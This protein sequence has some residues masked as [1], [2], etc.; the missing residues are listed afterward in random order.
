MTEEEKQAGRARFLRAVENAK[1]VLKPGDR[2]RVTKC[3]GRKRTITFAGWDGCWMVSKSGV[4]DYS[5]GCVDR[6]NGEEVDFGVV[7]EDRAD[8][9][10]RAN[11]AE[12]PKKVLKP[13]VLRAHDL[14]QQYRERCPRC[15]GE[16][17]PWAADGVR[18][19][20]CEN[21][22]VSEYLPPPSSEG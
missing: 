19:R 22:C 6:V 21:G 17:M 2:V 16:W 7:G 5:A 1:K 20:A 4:D 14:I 15:G 11:G 12:Q 10:D 13:G 8:G 3:P 9:A 18:G